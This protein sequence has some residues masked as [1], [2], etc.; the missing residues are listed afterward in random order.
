MTVM[1]NYLKNGQVIDNDN[2]GK[3]NEVAK[4]DRYFSSYSDLSIHKEMLEDQ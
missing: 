1:I 3:Q 2:Q 4:L